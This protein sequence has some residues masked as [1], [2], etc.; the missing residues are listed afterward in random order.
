MKKTREKECF[1]AILEDGSELSDCGSERLLVGH[2]P[3]KN[4]NKNKSAKKG[5]IGV[6]S[7]TPPAR[8]V[9]KYNRCL[10]TAGRGGGGRRVRGRSLSPAD[11]HET[12]SLGRAKVRSNRKLSL[13]VSGFQSH[14]YLP[15]KWEKDA[16]GRVSTSAH[17]RGRG[18]DTEM[19][20]EMGR[21]NREEKEGGKEKGAGDGKGKETAV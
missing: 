10:G 8:I 3:H 20:M 12:L 21:E 9:S 2:R 11:I 7:S 17:A 4:K 15:S 1:W 18:R 5:I 6:R 14:V 13:S 19:E 16:C